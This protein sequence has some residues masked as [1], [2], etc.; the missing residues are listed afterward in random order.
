MKTKDYDDEVDPNFNGE[1]TFASVN[2]NEYDSFLT[3]RKPF[4]KNTSEVS[5]NRNPV[6]RGVA[7]HSKI[8]HENLQSSMTPDEIEIYG[9]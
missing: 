2:R 9:F 4:S 5:S 7:A 1:E 3:E 6:L 8:P